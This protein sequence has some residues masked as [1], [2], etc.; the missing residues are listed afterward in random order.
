MDLVQ[1]SGNFKCITSKFLFFFFSPFYKSVYCND[2]FIVIVPG[3][4][5]CDSP[6]LAMHG[7]NLY[8]VEPYRVQVRTWQVKADEIMKRQIY[9]IVFKDWCYS[10]KVKWM[11]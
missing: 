11:F 2:G 4:F 9:L 1:D 7:E 10:L 5:L 8:T 3:S 6:V